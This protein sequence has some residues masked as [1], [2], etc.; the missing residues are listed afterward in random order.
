MKGGFHAENES[1]SSFIHK[2]DCSEADGLTLTFYLLCSLYQNRNF[3]V[4]KRNLLWFSIIT[5]F[6]CKVCRA[7]CKIKACTRFVFTAGFFTGF[8]N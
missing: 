8:H 3:V 4:C 5:T 1:R 6:F 7:S 2:F